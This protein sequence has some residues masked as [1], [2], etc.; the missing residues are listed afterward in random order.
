MRTYFSGNEP[1]GKYVGLLGEF[2]I[3]ENLW[4]YPRRTVGAAFGAGRFRLFVGE[5]DARETGTTG[6]IYKDI[7][8]YQ[9]H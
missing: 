6:S 4:R 1:K 5:V 2:I 9:Y 8:L 7:L 3:L